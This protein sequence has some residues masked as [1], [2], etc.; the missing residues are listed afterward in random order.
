MNIAIADGRPFFWQ[1]DLDQKLLLEDVEPGQEVHFGRSDGGAYSV[2]AFEE[3][4]QIL[5]HVPN[6]WLQ[7]AGQRPV[8]IY[9]EDTHTTYKRIFTIQHRE[10]PDDYV[11]TETEV[12]SYRELANK[13][14]EMQAET[15]EAIEASNAALEE[16]NEVIAANTVALNENSV[17]LEKMAEI[18][19]RL[20]AMSSAEEV[21]F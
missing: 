2:L 13:L 19:D 11:Y 18:I 15:L 9:C 1:W 3:N 16:S 4:G 6:A 7:N 21:A 14:T 5:A 12:M 8:Y 20:Y 10:K 17:T